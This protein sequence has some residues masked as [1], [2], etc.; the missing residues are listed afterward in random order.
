MVQHLEFMD[1][2]YCGK[3][4]LTTAGLCHHCRKSPKLGTASIRQSN[5]RELEEAYGNDED[6]SHMAVDGGYVPENDDFDYDEFIEKEFSAGK[7]RFGPL[8][9]KLWI[10]MTAWLLIAI[11]AGS[12][13]ALLF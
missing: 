12:I 10:W 8:E 11:F 7:R 9:M 3:R 5:R 13:V 4:M 2:S 1:C 6:E